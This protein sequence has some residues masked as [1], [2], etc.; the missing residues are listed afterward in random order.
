VELLTQEIGQSGLVS[1]PSP[2]PTLSAA[3]TAN[4]SAQTVQ[5]SSTTSMFVGE[6]LLIDARTS[7]EVVSLTAV[8]TSPSSISGIF[9]L[10]HA[11]GAPV[12]VVGVFPNGVMTTSTAT[13]LQLFG[14]IN[15]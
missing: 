12:N 7:Q 8:S 6:K 4:S 5:V 10:N 11:S 14:A 15:A 13:E 9:N 3:L 1:L 2:S